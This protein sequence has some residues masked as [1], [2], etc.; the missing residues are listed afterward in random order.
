[1]FVQECFVGSIPQART[2]LLESSFVKRFYKRTLRNC[3]DDA[4]INE[5]LRH[6]FAPSFPCFWLLAT[7]GTVLVQ[8][9]PELWLGNGGLLYRPL[10]HCPPHIRHMQASHRFAPGILVSPVV[11]RRSYRRAVAH[12]LLHRGQ[13]G[14]QVE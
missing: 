11:G 14:A 13:V 2:G 9:L 1:M 7:Y 4:Y 12:Q 10:A 5:M 8:I 3:F 6:N